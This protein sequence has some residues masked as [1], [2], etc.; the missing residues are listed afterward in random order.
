MSL[1]HCMHGVF[2]VVF[3]CV[4]HV[5]DYVIM[6]YTLR[7]KLIHGMMYMGNMIAWEKKYMHGIMYIGK[8][9]EF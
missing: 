7:G 9:V 8:K 4:F 5:C 6:C 2:H 3:E 1:D